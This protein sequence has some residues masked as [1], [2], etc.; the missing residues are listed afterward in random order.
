MDNSLTP[1]EHALCGLWPQHVFGTTKHAK[2]RENS[3]FLDQYAVAVATYSEFKKEQSLGE[4][5]FASFRAFRSLRK[6][7][8]EATLSSP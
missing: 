1:R 8:R 7:R 5:L 6:V 3:G 4:S 2:M